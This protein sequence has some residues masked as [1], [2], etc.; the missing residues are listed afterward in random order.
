M[1]NKTFHVVPN[2]RRGGWDVKR[3]EA[4]RASSHHDTKREAIRV[5]QKMSRKERGKLI[6]YKRDGSI[7]GKDSHGNDP[8]PPQG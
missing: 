5:A 4:A 1:P 2:C 3:G 7:A 6:M 8:F